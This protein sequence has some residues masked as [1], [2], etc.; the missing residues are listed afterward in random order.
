MII[1]LSLKMANTW[2]KFVILKMGKLQSVKGAGLLAIVPIIDNDIAVIDGRIETSAFY[3]EHALTNDV[4]TKCI[5]TRH[6][7]S[8]LEQ[9]CGLTEKAS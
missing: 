1:A 5:S 9:G 8:R 6:S 4:D 7:G 3:A 2:E